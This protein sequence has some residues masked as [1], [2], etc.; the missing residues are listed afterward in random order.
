MAKVYGTITQLGV[1]GSITQKGVRG[2]IVQKGVGG[3]IVE[4]GVSGSGSDYDADA[5]LLT[6]IEGLETELSAGQLALLNTFIVNLKAGLSID[7]LSDAFDV[8][9]ILANETPE[10]ALRNLVKRLHDATAV[11]SP[12]FTALEGFTGNGSSSY[13]DTNYNAKTQGINYTKDNCS[14]GVYCRT[15]TNAGA[16]I[17]AQ[18]VYP[19][20]GIFVAAR[21]SGKIYGRINERGTNNAMSTIA[22]SL[23]MTITTR[24]GSAYNNKVNYRNKTSPAMSYSGTAITD[25]VPDF[26]MYILGNNKSGTPGVLTTRQTSL[27]FAGKYITTGMRD[28]IVD[29]FEA[30]MNGKGV[31][32]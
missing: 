4:S 29:C 21:L 1:S 2:S 26:N 10:A 30:Y 8:I 17:G 11:N 31:I 27:A 9:Y 32:T 28:V 20:N 12:T 7:N 22:D 19:G 16:D 3:N 5:D 18:E 15:N 6:Y 13:I 14:L 25:R 24:N 23:G